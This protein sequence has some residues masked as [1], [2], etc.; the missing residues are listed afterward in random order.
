VEARN[1][2]RLIDYILDSASETYEIL[3]WK[4][5]AYIS[6]TILAERF[7]KK[8]RDLYRNR[9]KAFLEFPE[10]RRLPKYTFDTLLDALQDP[11]EQ[12]DAGS[13]LW[14]FIAMISEFYNETSCERIDV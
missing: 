9:L 2:K 6:R 7:L 12:K 14:K 11:T 3:N 5:D 1:F 8:D 4:T 10:P 13:V